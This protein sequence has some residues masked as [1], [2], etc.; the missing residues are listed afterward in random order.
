MVSLWYFFSCGVFDFFLLSLVCR[1][2]VLLYMC[3]I[4]FILNFQL[5]HPFILIMVKESLQN[6]VEYLFWSCAVCVTVLSLQLWNRFLQLRISCLRVLSIVPLLWYP[7]FF[8]FASWYDWLVFTFDILVRISRFIIIN[9][10][11]STVTWCALYGSFV[12]LLT[13]IFANLHRSCLMWA[14]V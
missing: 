5:R 8:N 1:L 7:A 13:M 10:G 3:W 14:C 6:G 2:L 4:T 11:V 9:A 12:A